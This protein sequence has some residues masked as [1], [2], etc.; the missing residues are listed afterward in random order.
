[1]RLL[2]TGG[3]VGGR[4]AVAEIAV[5]IVP[6][7]QLDD[8]RAEAGALQSPGEVMRGLLAGPVFIPIEDDVD[9]AALGIDQ[10]CVQQQ[11]ERATQGGEMTP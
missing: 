11:I 1:L 10:A 7:R 9:R 6:G 3:E 5:G 4:G 8:S 2:E